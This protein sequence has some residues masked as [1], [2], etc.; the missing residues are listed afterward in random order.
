M[1]KRLAV[2]LIFIILPACAQ[3]PT[4]YEMS[5][6]DYGQVP[7]SY[8]GLIIN[9][10][11][12]SLPEPESATIEVAKPFPAIRYLGLSKGGE[13]EY[14][15]VVHVW[16]TA[17]DSMRQGVQKSPKIFW[18]NNKGWNTMLPSLEGITP[19]YPAQAEEYTGVIFTRY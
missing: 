4:A 7:A 15:H 18:W 8:Q 6:A 16:V 14:G 2:F 5:K 17:K 12:G 13:Y 19:K 10:I 11:K 9:K 3:K 1:L